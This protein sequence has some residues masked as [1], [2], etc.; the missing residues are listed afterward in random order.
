MYELVAEVDLPQPTVL[1]GDTALSAKSF[2]RLKGL[3]TY[4]S[5]SGTDA[6]A[7]LT[8]NEP[9]LMNAKF[10]QT[11]KVIKRHAAGTQ[12]EELLASGKVFLSAPVEP[13]GFIREGNHLRNDRDEVNADPISQ[14]WHVKLFK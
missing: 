11:S 5:K 9:V 8:F 12:D 7:K 6:F 13:E 1:G 14:R 2:S 10:E 4:W 3:A